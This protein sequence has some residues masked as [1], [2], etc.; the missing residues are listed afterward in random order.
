MIEST[1]TADIQDY[2]AIKKYIPEA[3]QKQVKWI[4]ELVDMARK[5]GVHEPVGENLLSLCKFFQA[6]ESVFKLQMLRGMK[7]DLALRLKQR[8]KP[9]THEQT[10]Q[11]GLFHPEA[12]QGGDNQTLRQM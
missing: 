12:F 4:K 11:L 6:D 3:N 5:V 1:T 2:A 10:G 7:S 8:T 9:T